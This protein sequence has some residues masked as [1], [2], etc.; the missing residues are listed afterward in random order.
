MVILK[1]RPPAQEYSRSWGNAVFYYMSKHTVFS[2]VGILQ[3]ARD[4]SAHRRGISRKGT[5]SLACICTPSGKPFRSVV[6][7]RRFA[8]R[9]SYPNRFSYFLSGHLVPWQKIRKERDFSSPTLL[10]EGSSVAGPP[11][12]HWT[13]GGLGLASN[14]NLF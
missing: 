10:S 12:R 4:V 6:T 7:L 13:N 1:H 8:S 5:S 14:P 3:R 9:G 11:S 2:T